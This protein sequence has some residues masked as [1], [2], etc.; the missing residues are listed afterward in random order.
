ML[1]RKAD[2]LFFESAVD[3]ILNPL[4]DKGNEISEEFLTHIWFDCI[5][6]WVIAGHI[7]KDFGKFLS[8]IFYDLSVQ[9]RVM[10]WSAERLKSG[11]WKTYNKYEGL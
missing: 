1:N 5:D 6:K 3:E 7:T 2:L 9:S 8:T 11:E 10:K 4:S